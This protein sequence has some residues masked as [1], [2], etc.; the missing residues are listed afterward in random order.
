ME[1]ISKYSN[2]WQNKGTKYI[3]NLLV[4]EGEKDVR[5]HQIFSK[6]ILKEFENKQFL[7]LKQWDIYFEQLYGNYMKLSKEERQ[8]RHKKEIFG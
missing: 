8:P 7:V 3:G 6:G 5:E 4:G 1:K 2:L